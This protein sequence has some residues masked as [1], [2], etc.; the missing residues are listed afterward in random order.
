MTVRE[1]VDLA[2][3]ELRIAK[4]T[5]DYFNGSSTAGQAKAELLLTC[6]NLVENEL[7]LDY[8]SLTKEESVSSSGKVLFTALK[9]SPVRILK[10]TDSNGQDLAYTLYPSY[11]E[12]RR[13][14]VKISYVYT[15]NVKAIDEECDFSGNVSARLMAFGIA[16]EYCMATGS[17]EESALWDKKYKDAI[18]A[19]REKSKGG[20]M[21][22]R[23]WA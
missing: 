15:P 16:A 2:A 1:I 3:E 23:R 10:V 18:E 21:A 7:A 4:E 19:I 22:L 6:Y 13:G 20:R 11:I 12:V 8:F 17:F 14:N 9:N 5:T